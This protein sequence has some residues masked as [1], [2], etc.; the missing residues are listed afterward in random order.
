[1]LLRRFPYAKI[2][3]KYISQYLHRFT[4]VNSKSLKPST[5]FLFRVPFRLSRRP[6]GH[7]CHK[8]HNGSL[9]AIC[10]MIKVEE[11]TRSQPKRSFPTTCDPAGAGH[12]EIL[13]PR[14]LK[15]TLCRTFPPRY[16]F[17]SQRRIIFLCDTYIFS[18]VYLFLSAIHLLLS[19][20]YSSI[21]APFMG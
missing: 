14:L 5:E 13:H 19:A 9:L 17:A 15:F 4:L 11:S 8:R 18:V 12:A 3:Y 16:C 1:M 2:T 6:L 20:I 10:N 21:P 7:D